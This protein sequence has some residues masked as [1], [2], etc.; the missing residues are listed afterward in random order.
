MPNLGNESTVA[1]TEVW[2]FDALPDDFL[3]LC[4]AA[5]GSAN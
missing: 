1:G 4:D 2:L 3:A 5:G